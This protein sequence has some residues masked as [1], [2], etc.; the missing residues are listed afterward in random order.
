MIDNIKSTISQKY[1]LSDKKWIF[2][3]IF[4]NNWE[5]L[6]SNW[7][8]D[9]DK[10]L[11]KTIETLR[12]WIFEKEEKNTKAIV[13]DIVIDSFQ[14]T[15]PIKLAQLNM[16]KHWIFLSNIEKTK[17]WTILPETVWVADAKH[18]LYVLKQ[19]YTELNWNVLIRAFTTDRIII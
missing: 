9:S 3:S 7:V 14:E 4:G 10:T 5:L 6:L 15:D 19:K 1:K 18:A 12:L 17:S 16:K 13:V 2:I 11:D 8:I